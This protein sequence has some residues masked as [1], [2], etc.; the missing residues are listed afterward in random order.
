MVELDGGTNGGS[1]QGWM[2]VLCRRRTWRTTSLSRQA[3][4]V[5]HQVKLALR[6]IREEMQAAGGRVGMATWIKR[7]E[8]GGGALDSTVDSRPHGGK[9]Q[10]TQ[11]TNLP[12]YHMLG[13]HVVH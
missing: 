11:S 7:W 4:S 9:I 6:E 5:Y 12:F 3:M 8:C 2:A 13:G 10:R 1:C